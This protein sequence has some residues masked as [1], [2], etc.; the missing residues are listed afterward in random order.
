MTK[1]QTSRKTQLVEDEHHRM[2]GTLRRASRFTIDGLPPVTGALCL[3][4]DEAE[5]QADIL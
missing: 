5:R 1:N 3:R 2:R 4:F